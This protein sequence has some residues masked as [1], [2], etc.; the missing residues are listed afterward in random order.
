MNFGIEVKSLGKTVRLKLGLLQPSI[1]KHSLGQIWLLKIMKF[2]G[3]EHL[4][5]LK[6]L[7][8]ELNRSEYYS[9][10]CNKIFKR[11]SGENSHG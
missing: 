8:L 9:P 3:G 1:W 11:L 7:V 2:I 10:Q 6:F 5:V 4:D